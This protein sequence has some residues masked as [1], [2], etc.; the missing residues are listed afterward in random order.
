MTRMLIRS[1]C[2]ALWL[3]LMLMSSLPCSSLRAL[4]K[5]IF[6]QTKRTAA[7]M[8]ATESLNS[9]LSIGAGSIAGAIGIGTAYPLDSLKTKTQI[10]SQLNNSIDLISLTSLV[11]QKE[12]LSG[13]YSGVGGVMVGEAFVKAALF[14]SNSWLLSEL[15]VPG[16]SASLLQLTLAAAFSGFVS[17]FVLNPIERIKIL[18][19][20][21]KGIYSSEIDCAAKVISNDGIGGLLLRGLDGMMIREIPG[22]I[23]YLLTYSLLMNSFAPIAFGPAA[24]FFSGASAGV[25]AW[26]PIYPSDVVKTSMQNKLGSNSQNSI[27][28]QNVGFFETALQL[29]RTFGFGIF[30][31]G[32]QPKLLR[33]AVHHSVTF[34]FFEKIT[35]AL[36]VVSAG[37]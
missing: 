3:L 4:S 26:I 33:A 15:C 14:G 2:S 32:V 35:T 37:G 17:S 24:S 22:C 11:L 9:L 29:Q 27:D 19:Q 8:A 30:Y 5:N 25:C 20:G 7:R 16:E 21:N 18:M 1:S 6:L 13:F 23:V 34:Y 28:T 10:Y 31:Q 36:G 12:G